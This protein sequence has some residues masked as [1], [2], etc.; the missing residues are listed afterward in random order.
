[1]S[2]GRGNRA[3]GSPTALRDRDRQRQA[4]GKRGQPGG[5]FA[6]QRVRG[7]G[8]PGQPDRQVVAEPPQLVVPAP[9][10]QANRPVGEVGVLVADE[11]LN[12]LRVDLALDVGHAKQR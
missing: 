10:T 3:E 2:Q 1:M 5:L 8:R 7:A 12:Q 11:I 6:Q 9:R 4:R